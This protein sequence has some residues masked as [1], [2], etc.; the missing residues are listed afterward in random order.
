MSGAEPIAVV[1]MA[2]RVPGANTPAR[3]WRNILAGRD[4][5]TRPSIQELRRA[6]LSRRQL[7]DPQ[8]V[9]SRPL[10]NDIEYFDASFFGMAGF[11]TERIDPSHRLFLECVWEAIEAAAIVLGRSGSVTGVFGGGEG[12]YERENLDHLEDH[13]TTDRVW[14]RDMGFG[15]QVRLGNALDYFTTRVSHKLDLTGPSVAVRAACATSLVALDLAIGSLRRR[16]CDVAIVGGASVLLPQIAGYISNIHGMFSPSGRVKPFDAGADGTV[17]GNGVGVVVLRPLDDALADGNPIHAVIR[18]SGV[19]NDGNPDGKE[20]FVAPSPRGQIAAVEAAMVDAGVGGESIGYLEAHGTATLLGDPVEVSSI[21]DVYRRD[22]AK[23]RYCALGSVKGNVGHLR[24]AAGV[25]SLIKACLALKHRTLPPLANFA[26]HNP[27]IDFESSPFYVNTEPLKWVECAHPRRAAVSSFGFG[28]SNAHAVVEEYIAS[29]APAS[30]RRQHLYPLSA[31]SESALARRM[32]DLAA[33]LD[34]NPELGAADVA[35]TL[36]RGREAMAHRACVYVDEETFKPSD[37][38]HA[39]PHASGVAKSQD[40][41]VVFLFPGQG[42][43]RPGMGQDVYAREPVYRHAVDRCAELLDP[44]LGF[45]IRTLIHIEP[46]RSEGDGAAVLRQTANTQPALFVVEYALAKLF[47]SWGVKPEAMLGHSIGE[48]VAACIA[49]VFSLEDALKLVAARAKLMQ[50]CAPGA[51]AA[52]F[53]P[54]AALTDVLG[55]D[56]EIA[57]LNAPNISVVSG[58]EEDIRRFLDKMEDAGVGTRRVETSHAFHSRMMDPALPAFRSVVQDIGL[59]APGITVISNATGMVL[60]PEQAVD[61]DYWADHLRHTVRFSSGCEHLLEDRDR[62]FLELGPGRTLADLVRQHDGEADTVAILDKARRAPD[63]DRH[64]AL[65]AL[66]QLWC[67]GGRVDWH[68]F[69]AGE[70]RQK[71]PLPTYPFERR[72]YWLEMGETETK[73]KDALHLYEPGWRLAE[74]DHD[75]AEDDGR[76]WLLFRDECGLGLAVAEELKAQKRTVIS[77]IPGE[78]F[79]EVE[80]D[81][82]TVRPASKEDLQAVLAKAGA[83]DGG[84]VPQVL[85]LWSMTGPSGQHNTI[86]AFRQSS[87]TGFYTLIALMQA[88]FDNGMC[89]DLD[90]L[91]VADGLRQIEG[92]ETPLHAEKGALFGPAR[93]IADELPGMS[94]RCVDVSGFTDGNAVDELC[95]AIIAEARGRDRQLTI[96]LRP[97]G[98]Y[99]EEFY[100]LASLPLGRLRMRDRGTVLITGGVGSL[101]LHVAEALFDLAQ[102][103]LVLTSRWQPPPREEWPNRARADDKVGRALK[104]VLALEARGAELLIVTADTADMKSLKEGVATA[105]ARFGKINGVVHAAGINN[106]GPTLN[107]TPEIAEPVFEAKVHGAFNLDEIFA[108]S[109]LDFFV[110]FSS[111]ASYYSSSG[112]ASYVASNNVLDILSRWRAPRQR[113]LTCAIGWGAWEEVGMAAMRAR[114][115]KRPDRKGHDPPLSGTL[116]HP[117]MRTRHDGKDG[118]VIYHGVFRDGEHWICEHRF[119]GRWLVSGVTIL[120][121]VRATYVDLLAVD[122]SM[123]LSRIGFLRPLFVDDRG[124]EIEIEY[125][126][127]GERQSFEVRS[128]AL[129]SQE[130]FVVHTIGLATVARSRAVADAA[131]V[132]NDLSEDQILF[133]G[134]GD[135][136]AGPRW[137]CIKGIRR[138]ESTTWMRLRLADE[139]KTDLESFGLHP[140]LFDRALNASAGRYFRRAVPYTLDV[141]RIYSSLGAEFFVR[142][143]ERIVGSRERIVG[144]GDTFDGQMIDKR[145]NT[146]VEFGGFVMHEITGS[147]LD[148][149]TDAASRYTMDTGTRLAEDQRIVVTEPGDLDSLRPQKFEARAPRAGEVQIEVVA[150]GLN[151]RDILAALGQLPDEGGVAPGIGGECSGIVRA[152]GDDVLDLRP[153]DPVVAIAAGAF[154]GLVTT[155][156]EWV[157]PVPPTINMED[158]AGIAIVFLTADYAL[159]ELAGLKRGERILIHAAAGGVGLAAVQIGQQIGAEIFATAGHPDKRQYLKELGIEHVTDSRSLD[160]VDEVRERTNGEGVDVVLNSLAGEFIPA[161]LALL[162]YR[163][164]FLEIGKRDIQADTKVGLSP[165]RNNLG[166]DAIDLSEMIRARDPVVARLFES[167]MLRFSR[168]DLKPVPTTVIPIDEMTRGLK[169]MARAE[170]IGKIV[171]KIRDDPDPWRS[172]FKKFEEFYGRGVPV[173]DGLDTF[174]RLLSCDKIPPYVLALGKPIEVGLAKHMVGGREKSRPELNTSYR[175]PTCA[176]E[177]TLVRIW[178]NSLGMTPIGVDDDFFDLGGDSITAIQLQFSVASAYDIELP[179]MVLFDHSTICS[180]AKLIREMAN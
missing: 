134:S 114:D 160:F 103:R 179:T 101:G 41:P 164:R 39:A 165:F 14:M 49:G 35:H 29:P 78:A 7:V 32:T 87:L 123:E 127:D 88:A 170:H 158:A 126:P 21:A 146:L 145:G 135:F 138:E 68:D 140:A 156:A 64:M 162:R 105:E 5:L 92:E 93:T 96:C 159:N 51:M 9:R 149:S 161:S 54:E 169:R 143:T 121:C 113:G 86:E 173:T 111:Q 63:N 175:V 56:L 50:E 122:T 24:T 139:F 125:T 97:Q 12:G 151:F 91:V 4:S 166:Y 133:E 26:D 82:F 152:V 60:T 38:L 62:V 67:A 110:H 94:V 142:S 47:M 108:Q 17:F 84:R 95:N 131:P 28:G 31:K 73:A 44:E 136:T 176:E 177:E 33:H 148:R 155:S 46:G 98:R 10:L 115:P 99:V 180:L 118:H 34:E 72:R 81:T 117:L 178:E 59:K 74:L 141:I 168:G 119:R 79:A 104:R 57:A 3:F 53:L 27:R 8:L 2:L 18:G 132:P 120:E 116:K 85:H 150:A 75:E 144:V 167:L 137:N 19:S 171:F 23:R 69:Y 36:Q 107:T 61:P 90:V 124:S 15:L 106:L 13:S 157:L 100:S 66:G 174:R 70:R 163:G 153:G 109:S 129:G 112:Q 83:R 45:D 11:E 71:V 16:K 65:G 102:A 77:L 89:D 128:R 80:P 25:V 6:G 42:A 37:L 48:I 43:Q 1:G 147:S 40:R 20:S 154:A 76:P 172:I 30:S 58:P 55:D 130:E 22:T 52:V